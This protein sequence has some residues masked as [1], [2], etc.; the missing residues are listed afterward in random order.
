MFCTHCGSILRDTAKFCSRCGQPTAALRPRGSVPQDGATPNASSDEEAFCR[1]PVRATMPTLA[2]PNFVQGTPYCPVQPVRV[3]T[4][5]PYS[6]AELMRSAYSRAGLGS[7]LMGAIQGAFGSVLTVMLTIA[8]AAASPSSDTSSLLTTIVTVLTYVASMLVTLFVVRALLRKASD[9]APVAKQPLAGGAI[10]LYILAAFGVWGVGALLG[11]LPALFDVPRIGM[12]VLSEDSTLV[13]TILN[14]ALAVIAAPLLEEWIFRKLLIDR[15]HIFGEPTAILA[16][17]LLFG[18]VHGNSAQF[19]LA[20]FLGLLFGVLYCKTGKIRYTILLHAIINFF[21]SLP[22]LLYL[23]P[24]LSDLLAPYFAPFGVTGTDCID[25]LWYAVGGLLMLGGLVVVAVC[26]KR[27]LATIKPNRVSFANKQAFGSIG[28][29]VAVIVLLVSIV[30]M[31][32]ASIVVSFIKPFSK[33]EILKEWGFG[34]F[35]W[36][37]LI[38]LIPCCACIA[39]VLLTSLY[40]GKPVAAEDE[41]SPDTLCRRSVPTKIVYQRLTP[42]A[43][44]DAEVVIEPSAAQ[45]AE[46]P[47]AQDAEVVIEPSAPQDGEQP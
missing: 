42:Q 31:D 37:T 4:R 6:S 30:L 25:A 39:L 21:A 17:A 26:A 29:R 3:P 14:T 20:F 22:S 1:P 11:N 43:A 34:S 8:I 32:L 2:S 7:L 46:P 15:L 24:K 18:L 28:M 9:A 33:L 44:Q 5:A 10:L 47:A 36:K 35:D 12:T 23:F 13:T 16:S 40:K 19:F 38:L 41:A 27:T 45:D